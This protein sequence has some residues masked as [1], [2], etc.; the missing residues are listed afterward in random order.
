MVE[1]NKKARRVTAAGVLSNFEFE[2]ESEHRPSLMGMMMMMM[3]GDGGTIN[4]DY[5]RKAGVGAVCIERELN[6]SR[7]P[8]GG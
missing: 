1:R 5:S 2:C 8:A 3:P 4:F 6:E 7:A